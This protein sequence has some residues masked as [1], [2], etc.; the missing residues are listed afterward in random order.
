[1]SPFFAMTL[2]LSPVAHDVYPVFTIIVNG[3]VTNRFLNLSILSTARNINLNSITFYD[4][5]V[6]S[7]RV[8]RVLGHTSYKI[9]PSPLTI[10]QNYW[11]IVAIMI[12]YNMQGY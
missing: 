7:T 2:L 9:I 4:G 3:F 11:K 5:L 12:F 10:S 6:L 8:W 1:M